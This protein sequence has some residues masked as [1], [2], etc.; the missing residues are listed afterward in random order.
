MFTSKE[1]VES[2]SDQESKINV[3]LNTSLYSAIILS[4]AFK[5]DAG[6]FAIELSYWFDTLIKSFSWEQEKRINTK[7]GMRKNFFGHN[8]T[9]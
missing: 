5:R 8:F 6:E 2:A 9:Y 3:L 4:L 1:E 7:N